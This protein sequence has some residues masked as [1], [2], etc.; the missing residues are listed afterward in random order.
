LDLKRWR[1]RI[2]VAD[3]AILG[4]ALIGVILRLRKFF[5]SRSLWLDE[6]AL[7]LNILHQSPFELFGQLQFG[8]VAPFGFLLIEQGF[9]RLLGG[10]EK[11]LRLFP[12][13]AGLAALAGI[14]LLS[15][16]LL[17]KTGWIVA[18]GLI[19]IAPPLV[20]YSSELK[21]YSSDVAIA[22][23]L[24]LLALSRDT[25]RTNE[26]KIVRDAVIGAAAVWISYPALFVLAGIG[27]VESLL[28][29]IHS[30]WDV[31]KRNL[32]TYT[33]WGFSSLAVILQTSAARARLAGLEHWSGSFM[34]VPPRSIS[35]LEWFLD[36][37]LGLFD[38]ALG[39]ATWS[40]VAAL[41]IIGFF[42]LL[43]RDWE[44]ALFI[45]S[46]TLFL[47]VASGL[48]VYPVADRA[49]LFLAGPLAIC[50]AATFESVLPDSGP[51]RWLAFILLGGILVWGPIQRDYA[52]FRTPPRQEEV[53]DVVEYLKP[54]LAEADTIY[55]YYGAEPAFRY[56]SNRLN[57][58]QA[59]VIYGSRFRLEPRQYLD[60][61]AS[62]L[63]QDEMWFV[64]AHDYFS[65]IGN[66]REYILRFLDCLGDQE[67]E[68]RRPGAHLY[69]YGFSGSVNSD[70][71]DVI[72]GCID[73]MN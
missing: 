8:Q 1:K 45:A 22:M 13:I 49:I 33:V 70:D 59:N 10:G 61:L 67:L 55:V 2:N 21:P 62:G 12:L 68:Y 60:E 40:G 23:G 30:K 58:G 71:G 17:S 69:Q 32:P 18:G 35:D 53:R 29:L 4:I 47:L 39:L 9:A 42:I 73:A 31:F 51:S 26:T 34:P 65:D 14:I 72:D 56:Y 54:R 52:S 43:Q 37:Y 46:P 5:F 27:F 16:K 57:L 50:I 41:V 28:L 64:F 24:L 44:S 19:A 48:Q 11:I 7:A 36:R 15:R 66:E 38:D 63:S 6:A 25:A 20:H 3:V